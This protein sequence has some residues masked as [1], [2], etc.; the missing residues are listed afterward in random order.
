L[1]P[2]K[3][4]QRSSGIF[5]ATGT[6]KSFLTRLILAG[7]INSNVAGALIF[8]MHN[9][10]GPDDTASDTNQRIPGLKG[11]FPAK[12]RLVGLGRGSDFRDVRADF[13]LEIAQ[14]DIET[15]D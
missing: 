1:D 13:N 5:G 2:E 15:G 4:V 9:E 10:Y 12:V 14:R 7:L 11:K 3:F 8:D 6:G